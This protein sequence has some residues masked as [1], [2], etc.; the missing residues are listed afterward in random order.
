MAIDT[1]AGRAPTALSRIWV[2]LAIAIFLG[3]LSLAA[4]QS[5]SVEC[6]DVYLITEDGRYITTEA[7]VR[8]TTGQRECRSSWHGLPPRP[9][10]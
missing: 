4:V 2:A 1:T 6:R 3:L 7:G 8:L 5:I 9:L 10:P